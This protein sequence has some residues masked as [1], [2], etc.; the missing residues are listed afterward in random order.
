MEN[1]KLY[2]VTFAME[3]DAVG[4]PVF[5]DE[6]TIHCDDGILAYPV[7][8]RFE[9]EKL[10]EVCTGIEIPDL[11]DRSIPGFG[12]YFLSEVRTLQDYEESAYFLSSVNNNFKEQFR[13]ALELYIDSY[14]KVHK[15][16]TDSHF[17][18]FGNLDDYSEARDEN[19]QERY[20]KYMRITE[21]MISEMKPKAK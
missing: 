5:R 15:R 16:Y 14:N 20:D 18:E 19:W 10:I 3:Y 7:Y 4:H 11:M 6:L 13:N 17:D 9:G 21:N 8:G 12:A 2:K 1:I